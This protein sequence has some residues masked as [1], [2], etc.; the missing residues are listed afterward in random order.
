MRSMFVRQAVLSFW[1]RF[2]SAFKE[3]MLE[4]IR[5]G[6]IGFE[7]EHAIAPRILFRWPLGPFEF[8]IS[9]AVVVSWIMLAVIFVLAWLM[10]R[11]RDMIPQTGRQLISEN[12]VDI[13]LKL[14]Q[15][16]GMS[17]EQ[18]ET[19]VPFVGTIGIFITLTNLSSL[20]KI[21][22]PA[23]NPAFPIILAL[24]TVVYV[25]AISIHFV[26]LRGFWS[27]LIYP[28]AL[29]L[30]FKL[31]DFVI[32]P[33]SLSLRLFG[34]VFGAF[35]LMEFIYII[36]PVLIPGVIGLWFDLADGILQGVIFTYLSVTYIGEIVEGAHEAAHARQER[37]QAHTAAKKA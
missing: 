12:L 22:P 17:Y 32:K 27:S 36:I 7:I 18:A 21:P 2:W 6:D 25:I 26:G 34:N 33:I 3:D 31:L 10:G 19:V 24:L 11:K 16:A 14:C 28:K 9:D 20:F 23:K 8:M 35:I 15:N 1:P 5:I 13:L 29:L 37:L 30:P 4:E